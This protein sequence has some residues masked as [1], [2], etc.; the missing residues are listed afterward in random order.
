MCSLF[1]VCRLVF[2]V[3][4][5]ALLRFVYC[6]VSFVVYGLLCGVNCSVFTGCCVLCDVCCLL[7]VNCW[8]AFVVRCVLFVV[9]CPLSVV[10]GL[11]LFVDCCLFVFR[12]KC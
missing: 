10:C 7:F 9:R 6:V 5:C 8:L 1:V 12:V 4:W 11:L 3:V 2:V